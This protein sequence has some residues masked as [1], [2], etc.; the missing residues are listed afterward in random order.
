MA[1]LATQNLGAGGPYTLAAAAGGGDTIETGPSAGG[2]GPGSFLIANVG[3]T[4]TTI[5]VDGTAYGPYTSQTVIVPVGKGNNAGSR[6]NI[7]YNQVTSVTVG[8][9]RLGSAL[10][11]ITYGT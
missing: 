9:V 8:A 5:T 3:G 10:T 1:A 6:V 4:A 2:W 7:T 11:G